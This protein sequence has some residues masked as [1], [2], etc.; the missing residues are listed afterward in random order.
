MNPQE[1]NEIQRQVDDLLATGMTRESLSP[2]VVLALLVPE[3]DSSMRMC[4]DSRA[5]NKIIIKYKYPIPRLGDLLDAVSYTHLT[6][7]TKRI[8]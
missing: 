7:P 4:V 3:K 1:T 8:V 6:L 2:Y 5:I